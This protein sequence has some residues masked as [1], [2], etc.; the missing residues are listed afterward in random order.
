MIYDGAIPDTTET[1]DEVTEDRMI[2][3]QS[4]ASAAA[5]VDHAQEVLRHHAEAIAAL[6]TTDNI[7]AARLRR[8]NL[9]PGE[10]WNHVYRLINL[11]CAAKVQLQSAAQSCAATDACNAVA[12]ALMVVERMEAEIRALRTLMAP[13]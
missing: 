13:R 10:E 3:R 8:T 11:V 2:L 7:N 12:D 5:T 6:T 9:P 1:E 4:F